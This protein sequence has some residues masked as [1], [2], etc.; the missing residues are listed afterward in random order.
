MRSGG[1][2]GSVRDK[3]PGAETPAHVGLYAAG[4]SRKPVVGIGSSSV[5]RGRLVTLVLA[6]LDAP[7]HPPLPVIV[8]GKARGPCLP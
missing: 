4:G 3:G 5:A 7:S 2:G 1:T 6:A 8:V